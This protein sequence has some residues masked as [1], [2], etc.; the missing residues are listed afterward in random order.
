MGIVARTV[1][2]GA[3]AGA[4]AAGGGNGCPIGGVG[5]PS[6]VW[7]AARAAAVAVVVVLV[8]AS[9]SAEPHDVQNFWPD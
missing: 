1:V 6:A 5:E 8:V 7:A 9:T 2:A 3:V 4:D